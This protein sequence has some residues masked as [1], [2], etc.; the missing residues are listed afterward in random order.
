MFKFIRFSNYL[1]QITISSISGKKPLQSYSKFI[2]KSNHS[3]DNIDKIYLFILYIL[4]FCIF[5]SC[6]HKT[7]S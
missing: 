3:V 6:L 7:F 5:E 1:L 2:Q 4:F